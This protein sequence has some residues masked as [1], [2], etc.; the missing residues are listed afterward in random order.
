MGMRFK[1]HLFPFF[2]FIDPFL[3]AIIVY[4][5]MLKDKIRHSKK[6]EN[7]KKTLAIPQ[8]H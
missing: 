5:D 6:K 8:N 2:R 1:Q 7:R 3:D 4:P